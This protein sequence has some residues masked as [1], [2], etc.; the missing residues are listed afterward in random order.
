MVENK[1]A[2]GYTPAQVGAFVMLLSQ[3]E[4]QPQRGRFRTLGELRAAM[5]CMVEKVGKTARMSPF[6]PFLIDRK[7]VIRLDDGTYYVEGW[8][9]WQ[10]GNWQVAE[11]MRRVRERKADVTADALPDDEEVTAPVTGAVTGAVTPP[12]TVGVTVGV[13]P[14][15]TP[16]VT[17]RDARRSAAAATPGAEAPYV[18]TELPAVSR[19]RQAASETAVTPLPLPPE[20]QERVRELDDGCGGILARQLRGP[21]RDLVLRWASTL[22]RAGEL[23]AVSEVLDVVAYEMRRPTPDGTLPVNLAWC[24][25]AVATLARERASPATGAAGER[26]TANSQLAR[27]IEAGLL[28]RQGGGSS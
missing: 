5:D 7:D 21:E 26:L 6:V 22:R 18:A 15:V 20:V 14:A 28:Q 16:A 4:Q 27:R 3:A 9:E 1:L 24:A 11:R 23:V 8:D 2:A 13:T 12:V 19:Q 25:D 17:A 10:E